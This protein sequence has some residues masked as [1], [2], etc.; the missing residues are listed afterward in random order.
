LRESVEH[1]KHFYEDENYSLFH[2][3]WAWFS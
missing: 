2:F 3:F 1:L